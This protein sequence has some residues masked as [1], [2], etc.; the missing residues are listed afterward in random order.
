MSKRLDRLIDLLDEA[1]DAEPEPVE[2][3]VEWTESNLPPPPTTK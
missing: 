1:L 3:E 2:D